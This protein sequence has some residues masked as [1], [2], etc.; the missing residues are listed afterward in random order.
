MR[1]QIKYILLAC[2]SLFCLLA[3]S[4]NEYSSVSLPVL[5]I[6]NEQ[7]LEI[8]DS[9][10]ENDK[11]YDF[12]DSSLVYI[13][14]IQHAKYTTLVQFTSSHKLTYFGNESG[15]FISKGH[16]VIVRGFFDD[17]LFNETKDRK[18]FNYFQPS[19]GEDSLGMV[20]IDIYEDDS[21]TQWLYK[22]D[23]GHFIKL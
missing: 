6:E 4:Q 20:K 23:A 7:L 14:N 13:V 19:S 22:Y 11:L 8:I 15:C 21:Y 9:L 1:I 16:L 3:N 10:I 18:M 12:Y 5:K 17:T 2:L